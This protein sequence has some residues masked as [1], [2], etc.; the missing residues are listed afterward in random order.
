MAVLSGT[1]TIRFG[2][3]DHEDE[4]GGLYLRAEKGDIFVIPAGIAHKTHNPDP[5]MELK[6][7]TPGGGHG[8]WAEDTREKLANIEL[9]GFTMIGA[10]PVGSNWDWGK[11]GDHVGDYK[12]VWEVPVPEKDPVLGSSPRGLRGLWKTTERLSRL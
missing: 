11:A 6:F 2:S 7:L 3:A 12:S 9:S 5:E 10:Y 4:S 1:A 8:V